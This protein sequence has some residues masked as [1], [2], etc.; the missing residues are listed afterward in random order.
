M[1]WLFMVSGFFLTISGVSCRG[2]FLINVSQKPGI[3]PTMHFQTLGLFGENAAE[4][5]QLSVGRVITEGKPVEL[6]WVVQSRSGKPERFAKIT[7]GF[8]PTGFEETVPAK[9]LV[10]GAA[11]DILGAGPGSVGGTRFTKE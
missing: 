6:V 5:R 10:T 1:K 2:G 4:I 11:Y 7:Y 3:P 9:P 8:V